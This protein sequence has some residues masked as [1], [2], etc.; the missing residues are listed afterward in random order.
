MKNL[1]MDNIHDALGRFGTVQTLEDRDGLKLVLLHVGEPDGIY[2][3]VAVSSNKIEAHVSF[4]DSKGLVPSE[5]LNEFCRTH[6]GMQTFR[7][8]DSV[9]MDWSLLISN[10]WGPRGDEFEALQEFM[11]LYLISLSDL[12][13][14]L[15]AAVL[16]PDQTPALRSGAAGDTDLH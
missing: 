8:G 3:Q 9:Q 5:T 13:K 4:E 2:V 15:Q 11:L 7:N 14:M 10:H 16:S 6:S 1:T 12:H